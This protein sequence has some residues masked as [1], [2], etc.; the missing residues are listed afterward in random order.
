MKDALIFCGIIAVLLLL[1]V[2]DRRALKLSPKTMPETSR[3]D[4]GGRPD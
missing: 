1:A 3:F 2:C 4:A